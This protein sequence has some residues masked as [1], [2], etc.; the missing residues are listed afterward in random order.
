MMRQLMQRVWEALP[1]PAKGYLRGNAWYGRLSRFAHP[2]R[3]QTFNDEVTFHRKLFRS[4]G[5]SPRLIFD[6]GANC[7]EKTAVYRELDASVVAVEPTPELVE[8]LRERYP[9]NSGVVVVHCAGSSSPGTAT[10]WRVQKFGGAMNTINPKNREILAAGTNTRTPDHLAPEFGEAVSVETKTLDMLVKE[11]GKPAYIKIDAEG[12]DKEIIEGLSAPVPMLSFEAALPEFVEES[13]QAVDHLV[14][15]DP[16]AKFQAREAG[17][18]ILP[19]W[20]SSEEIKRVLR[21]G[22]P[23]LEVF[24]AMN[25]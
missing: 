12:H 14:S 6:V 7:G 20:V 5:L 15:L 9:A 16:T 18:F 24:A 8:H 13:C 19:Q 11:F 3:G 22:R 17:D 23:Y 1:T 25:G 10:L 4:S 21:G 2:H